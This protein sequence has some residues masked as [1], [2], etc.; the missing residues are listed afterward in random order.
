MRFFPVLGFLILFGCYSSFAIKLFSKHFL[1]WI[2]LYVNKMKTIL[3]FCVEN[4]AILD[5]IKGYQESFF[6]L[7]VSFVMCLFSFSSQ[8]V[9]RL[10]FISI[11]YIRNANTESISFKTETRVSCMFYNFYSLSLLEKFFC[12][13]CE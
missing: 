1:L 11:R 13:V 9:L 10:D 7:D 12:V 8:W 6:F 2:R 4:F 5:T 3:W